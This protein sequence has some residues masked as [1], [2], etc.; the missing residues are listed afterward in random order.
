MTLR[1]RC[2]EARLAILLLTRL[3]LGRLAETVPS[4]SDA[5]WAFPLAGFPLGMIGWVVF[6]LSGWVGLP[7]LSASVA[8]ICALSLATGGLHH[9]GLAD[10]ADG[11]WGGDDVEQRLEIMRD[12][13]IGSYGVLALIIALGLQASALAD[14]T[15]DVGLIEFLF[16]AVASRLTMLSVLIALPAARSDG[17]GKSAAGG[18]WRQIIPGLVLF[19]TLGLF[20]TSHFVAFLPMAAF[21]AGITLFSRKRLGGQT[22]DVL[23]ATQL[24]TEIA[25]WTTLAALT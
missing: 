16:I 11:I 7:P 21:A 6:A 12:S 10:F 24:I 17:L 18:G 13:R 3:P 20:C 2:D 22:G 19:L 9:D 4:L 8:T 1:R 5:R 25:G 23:G 15:P 14:L